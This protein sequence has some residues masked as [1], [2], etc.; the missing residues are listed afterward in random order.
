MAVYWYIDAFVNWVRNTLARLCFR[1]RLTDRTFNSLQWV[2]PALTYFSVHVKKSPR[3]VR[4]KSQPRLADPICRKCATAGHLTLAYLPKLFCYFKWFAL[5]ENTFIITHS[6]I[7]ISSQI[8]LECE[9]VWSH[10][11][12][13][14]WTFLSVCL[15][16]WAVNGFVPVGLMSE[17]V[18]CFCVLSMCVS[19]GIWSSLSHC[20]GSD[21][22]E[23]AERHWYRVKILGGDVGR[24]LGMDWTIFKRTKLYCV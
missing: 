11:C 15:S 4:N 20:G 9:C 6:V 13:C 5:P 23:S 22:V 19:S 17:C 18:L 1:F 10:E 21:K 8:K 7:G 2:Y 24:F 14:L 3:S 12:E 16:V